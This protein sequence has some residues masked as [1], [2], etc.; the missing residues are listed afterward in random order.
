MRKNRYTE[1]KELHYQTDVLY[2][3]NCWD[4]MSAKII[5]NKGAKALATS[6]YAVSDANG[7]TDG[8]YL[9]FENLLQLSEKL[10]QNSNVPV[11]IDA[12]GFYAKSSES[13]HQNAQKLFGTG[14]TGVNFE[15]QKPQSKE[16]ALWSVDEQSER[17]KILK[18]AAEDVDTEIFI[19]ARTDVFF[20]NKNHSVELV[21]EALNR[22]E[23]YALAGADCI[24]I[25]GLTEISLIKEFTKHSPL[26][27]NI[28]LNSFNSSS[29]DWRSLGVN[30]V[31]YGPHSYF[32]MKET[33]LSNL[34]FKV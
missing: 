27:V 24:F 23:S 6:S 30:R 11:S 2:L 25:P 4:V 26:P 34:V 13:L 10:V 17:I 22:A 16:Y 8:E 12:E 31:S 28:M 5:E 20:K 33:L 18:S 7:Y 29:I 1:F 21:N 32:Q 19:N 14:I 9:P 15:D 3:F